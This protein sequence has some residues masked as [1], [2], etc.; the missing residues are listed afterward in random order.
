VN[1]PSYNPYAPPH[2]ES[3]A[4]PQTS[5]RAP[6]ERLKWVYA[7]TA[8]VALVASVARLMGLTKA[9]V[10]TG[11]AGIV[12]VVVVAEWIFQ[13]WNGVPARFRDRVTP[14]G[15]LGR[16]LV[17]VFNVYWLFVVN[18][19]LCKALDGALASVELP[20]RAPMTLAR[21]APIAHAL[22]LGVILLIGY[23]LAL[24]LPPYVG[25]L[26]QTALSA[27]IDVTWFVY[28]LRCDEARRE[29]ARTVP[30]TERLASF[31][32]LLVF[33]AVGIFVFLAV[34]QFL[35]PAPR[36]SKRIAP[37]APSAE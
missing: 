8:G 24:R 25:T 16:F 26:G 37:S 21:L 22:G 6:G 35:S 11:L 30:R 13:A 4:P 1:D 3:A 23:T 17:P 34:W 36:P 2:A 14:F 10:V 9:I 29:V 19:R 27:T 20:Q 15:A 28:M 32:P 31:W 12:E 5:D 7:G 18:T 33:G